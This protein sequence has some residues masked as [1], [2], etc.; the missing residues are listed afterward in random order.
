MV[1]ALV[2]LDIWSEERGKGI[3][4]SYLRTAREA[5]KPVEHQWKKNEAAVFTSEPNVSIPYGEA[6]VVRGTGEIGSE[7]DGPLNPSMG[8]N[9]TFK[10]FRFLHAQLS[11]NPPTCIPRPST[12]DPED[13]RAARAADRVIR[14]ALRRYGL[15]ELVDQTTLSVLLRGIGV[16]KAMHDPTL[17]DI[18]RVGKDGRSLLMEGDLSFQNVDPRRFYPD[19]AAR[20]KK[21]VR[22]IIEELRLPREVAIAKWPDIEAHLEEAAGGSGDATAEGSVILDASLTGQST[23]TGSRSAY[24]TVYEYWETGL[25]TNGYRGRYAVF[26]ENGTFIVPP[27]VSPHAFRPR[28]TPA[29][30]DRKRA[31]KK[32]RRKPVRARLPYLWMT[33]VDVPESIWGASFVEFCSPLQDL[34]NRLH[35][36][37]LSNLQAHG[38]ARVMM[39]DDTEITDMQLSNTPLDIYRYKA[40]PGVPAPAFMA[41][42]Q[43]PAALD[44]LIN[45]VERGIGDSAGT[46][47]N[48]FG[49]QSREQSGFSMQYAV[50]QGNL[51][52][53]RLFNKYVDFV[54]ELYRTILDLVIMHWTTARTI[55]VL[56]REKAFELIDLRGADIEGGYD[57][58]V[59][60]GTSLSLDPM[61]RRD[62]IMKLQPLLKA[63][64]VSDRVIL[65]MLKLGELDSLSDIT[66]L[67]EDRQREDFETIIATGVQVKP[68][69]FEDHD[70]M[71][72]YALLYVMTEEFKY[73]EEDQKQLI[74][75]HIKLRL[76]QKNLDTQMA[77]SLSGS[78]APAPE[79]GGTGSAPEAAPAAGPIGLPP[80]AAAVPPGAVAAGPGAAPAQ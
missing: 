9:L 24:V 38:S 32:V 76:R 70:G 13:R 27:V 28:P 14:F 33:D 55:E 8:I 26:L 46:N 37:M 16:V 77:N 78:G 45:R 54:E 50:N 3:L 73:L 29:E 10:N 34:S 61:T 2:K 6:D 25:P 40:R 67:A 36:T 11:A 62:E 60:Y 19:F 74:R 72:A 35:S 64:G 41:P 56:G 52:R 31:G 53:R 42:M 75:E 65:S 47:E 7:R 69:E 1:P 71:L 63:A 58:V 22:W 79:V 48:M 21:D 12:A 68:R 23:A 15:Q 43:L 18:L 20:T 4:M 59:E 17:G 51:I 39:S 5:K 66:Q 57:L 44:D 30:M 49:M 80:E